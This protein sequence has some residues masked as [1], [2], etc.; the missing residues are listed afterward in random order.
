MVSLG[1]LLSCDAM[2][3]SVGSQFLGEKCSFGDRYFFI[4]FI[5]KF[6]CIFHNSKIYHCIWMD[7][8]MD[9]DPDDQARCTNASGI[10]LACLVY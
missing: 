5:L 10:T 4:F 7:L 6:L 1:C 3:F 9:V 2:F 8:Y